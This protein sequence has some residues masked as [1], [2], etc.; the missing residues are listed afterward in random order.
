MQ[1]ERL[2]DTILVTGKE[3]NANLPIRGWSIDERATTTRHI[4]SSE[5]D[6]VVFRL[7]VSEGSAEL[8]VAAPTDRSSGVGLGYEIGQET[9]RDILLELRRNTSNE[10]AVE[11]MLTMLD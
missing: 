11:Y 8:E 2:D 9:A 6:G 1:V 7:R 4:I 5:R 3:H 10:A